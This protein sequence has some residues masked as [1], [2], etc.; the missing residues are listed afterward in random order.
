MKLLRIRVFAGLVTSLLF[1]ICHAASSVV[2][3]NTSSPSAAVINMP[4]FTVSP[5]GQWTIVITQSKSVYK[6]Q[7]I[8]GTQ[9]LSAV[10][11]ELHPKAQETEDLLFQRYLGARRADQEKRNGSDGSVVVDPVSYADGENGRIGSWCEIDASKSHG[12]LSASLVR[13]R[14]ILS[15][16]Y[17]S[18]HVSEAEFRA[19][20][21]TLL[22]SMALR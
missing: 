15:I 9:K 19:R 5:P 13:N 2:I 14:K 11:V 20:A 21:L 16:S 8:D 10:V 4:S 12:V 22:S 3:D 6:F 1:A 17:E 7:S 18:E